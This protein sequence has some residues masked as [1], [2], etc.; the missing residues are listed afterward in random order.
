MTHTATHHAAVIDLNGRLIDD[1]EFSATPAGYAARWTWMRGKGKRRQV[2]VEGNRRLRRRTGP[3]PAT[4]ASTCWKSRARTAASAANAAKRPHRRRNRSANR[5]GR[6]K[7]RAE[8][9]DGPIEAIRMLR[10]A[11]NGAVEGPHRRPEHSAPM[12]ITAPE[13]LRTQLRTLSSAQLVA[14]CARLRPDLGHLA[15]PVQAA[16]H[17]LRSLPSACSTS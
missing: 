12:L 5:A 8:L 14:A 6:A 10:V 7:W 15:D 17:A 16:K 3:P 1:A 4:R 2:G 13:P 11:R 9:A